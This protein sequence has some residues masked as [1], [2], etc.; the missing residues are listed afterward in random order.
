M[1]LTYNLI[2]TLTIFITL[3]SCS[4]NRH[5]VKDTAMDLPEQFRGV[6]GND[7]ASIASIVWQDF[8]TDNVLQMLI[9]KGLKY[10]HD[11]LLAVQRIEIAKQYVRQGKQ[12]WLPELG[13]NLSGTYNYPSENGLNRTTGTF[14]D[15]SLGIN[16]QWEIDI[17]GKIRN[18]NKI[19]QAEYLRSYEA[20]N[21]IQTALISNIATGY[22]NLL[23]L[24]KQLEI[25]AKNLELADNTQRITTLLYE[26]GEVTSLA[27]SQVKAQRESVA[28]LIPKLQQEII[29]Q[30]NALQ[31][32]TGQF[33]GEINRDKN[34]ENI[35]VSN[36]LNAGI[37][38]SILS[39][40]P[41][42]RVTEL[43]VHTA[44]YRVGIAKAEMYPSLLITAEGG[45]ET[46]KASDWFNIPGSLFGIVAGNL[47][48]PL[49]SRRKLKTEYEVAQLEREQSVIKFRQI[50]VSAV[51]DA[52]NTIVSIEKIKEQETIVRKQVE[53][54]TNAV[55][56]ADS[57]YREG[58][59]N[60]I[61]V[62]TAQNRL[63]EAELNSS[64]IYYLKLCAVSDLYRSLGGGVNQ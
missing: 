34:I 54:L 24:D 44:N 7:T 53:E 30:E 59:A 62:I 49:F 60:Y 61:E 43:D 39:C 51:A 15:Y 21:A 17:W 2:F 1:K 4:I 31:E 37:P 56:N 45:L 38:V 50:V 5:I 33:P 14:E 26:E 27:V 23:L 6:S 29:L 55:V 35:Q 63:L 40:R 47:T 11:L 25:A 8:Y 13:L 20:K 3:A 19:I 36:S 48:R 9:E 12:L 58:M 42:V 22:Y 16:F 46:L 10:N 52:S 32:L 18:Q 41:D 28:L 57:L 64:Y